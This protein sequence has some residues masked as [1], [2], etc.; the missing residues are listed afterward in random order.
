MDVCLCGICVA[1]MCISYQVSSKC[2]C[3]VQCKQACKGSAPLCQQSNFFQTS[4]TWRKAGICIDHARG[5]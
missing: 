4:K 3:C 1:K 5:H 2:T